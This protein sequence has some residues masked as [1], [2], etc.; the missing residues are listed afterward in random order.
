MTSD[1][2]VLVVLIIKAGIGSVG[3]KEI[4]ESKNNCVYCEFFY[5]L[6][7]LDETGRDD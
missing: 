3:L 4:N 5:C 1:L 7:S 2:M 6:L